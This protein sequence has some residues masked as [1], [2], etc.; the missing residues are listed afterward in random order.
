MLVAVVV[1]RA[2]VQ[3]VGRAEVLGVVLAVPAAAEVVLRVRRR[4]L[5]L[6]P[7]RAKGAANQW[8][9]PQVR[10]W[11]LV[12]AQVALVLTA[13]ARPSRLCL[14]VAGLPL[15]CPEE[16]H[17]ET[18]AVLAPRRLQCKPL[19]PRR[20]PRSVYRRASASS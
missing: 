19:R 13:Q 6:A 7:H 16:E 15:L 20:R 9:P 17:V 4:L 1:A 18:V 2:R 3:A 8:L 10:R 14:V 5:V 12:L 11:V